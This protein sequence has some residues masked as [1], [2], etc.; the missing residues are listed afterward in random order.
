MPYPPDYFVRVKDND[1]RAEYSIPATASREGVTVI[2]KP[3]ATPAGEPL[4]AKTSTNSG[5][6]RTGQTAANEGKSA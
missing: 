6:K 5:G 3:A 4:P 1:T 2:D